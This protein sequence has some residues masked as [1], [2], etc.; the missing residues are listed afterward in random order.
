M[1]LGWGLLIGC[2][3]IGSSRV[4]MARCCSS[5]LMA[6]SFRKTQKIR[7]EKL[8]KSVK[9][10]MGDISADANMLLYA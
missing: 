8:C 5:G 3:G 7:D 2:G 10:I 1:V 9:N 6:R 4:D